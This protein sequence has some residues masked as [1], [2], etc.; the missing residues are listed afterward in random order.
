MTRTYLDTGVL[1]AAVRGGFEQAEAA[2]RILDDPTREFVASEFLRLEIL[3]KPTFHHRTEEQMFYEAFFESVVEWA[4][5]LT[6]VT[7]D[8][9]IEA[10]EHGLSA[11]DSLHI[12]SAIQLNADEFIT[13]EKS[14]K[15]IFRTKR[16]QVSS[17]AEDTV[18]KKN[19]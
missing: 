2:F 15:P 17:S 4:T 18:E 11:M 16:I 6:A 5:D 13:S 12:A 1:I 7:Q 19:G 9:M 3:P 8:A 10:C 14:S